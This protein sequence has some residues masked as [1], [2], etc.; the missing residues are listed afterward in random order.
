MNL[1]SLT[2][3]LSTMARLMGVVLTIGGIAFSASGQEIEV[4]DI[5][6]NLGYRII[7]IQEVRPPRGPAG[8]WP[9]SGCFTWKFQ[10][11]KDGAP[12][13]LR[14]ENGSRNYGFHVAMRSAL[15]QFRFK[16]MQPTDPDGLHQI[17]FRYESGS[18]NATP[19]PC[20]NCIAPAS[21]TAN[22]RSSS[23][24]P[25]FLPEGPNN[26]FKPKPLRSTKHMAGKACH[27]FGSTTRLGLT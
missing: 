1:S 23:A 5:D 26:A 14:V 4:H 16:E 8:D 3:V 15:K 20:C 10:I 12:Y 9:E 19:V 22:L 27:V 17:G 18:T 11:D 21:G 7:Q 6:K 2:E 25:Q 13:N 24:D